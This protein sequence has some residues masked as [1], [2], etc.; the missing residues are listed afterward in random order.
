MYEWWC[1]CFLF[2]L[3]CVWQTCNTDM[4][5]KKSE[6]S[7]SFYLRLCQKQTLVAWNRAPPSLARPKI[8]TRNSKIKI[9]N[10]KVSFSAVSQE[11]QFK[12]KFFVWLVFYAKYS[13]RLR[14]K[15]VKIQQYVLDVCLF[16]FIH[17]VWHMYTNIHTQQ[18]KHW[19][20]RWPIW[21]F[22]FMWCPNS[23]IGDLIVDIVRCVCRDLFED[24][25][26][27]I[28]LQT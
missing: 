6:I 17:T 23:N 18:S 25:S 12:H 21:L 11:K 26:K 7:E 10:C 4:E 27:S 2:L 14:D 15:K 5:L 24:R 1:V 20:G 9:W 3:Q 8:P 16:I 22:N 28:H 19:H 13:E